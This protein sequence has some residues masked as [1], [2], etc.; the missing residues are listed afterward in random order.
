MLAMDPRIPDKYEYFEFALTDVP[1]VEK[2]KWFVN[3]KLVAVTAK[4]TYDWKLS[5][6]VFHSRAEVFLHGRSKPVVTGEV[7]YRVN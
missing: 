7:E 2:V 3:G 5:R 4:P 6:G 1:G